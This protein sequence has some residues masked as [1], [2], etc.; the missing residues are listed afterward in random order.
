VSIGL[1]PHRKRGRGFGRR[2]EVAALREQALIEEARRRARQRRLGNLAAVALGLAVLFQVGFFPGGRGS[3]DAPAARPALRTAPADGAG[4]IAIADSTGSLAVVNPDGSA[5]RTLS[6]CTAPRTLRQALHNNCQVAEPAWSPDGMRLAFVRGQFPLLRRSAAASLYVSDPAATRPRLLARCGSCGRQYA[7]ERGISWSPDGTQIAFSATGGRPAE[8]SLFMVD[9]RSGAVRRLTD[10]VSG[11]ADAEP[12]WSPDGQLIVFSRF[13]KAGSSL[14]TVRPD[15]SGL[16]KI[17]REAGA[18]DPRWSPD[19]QLIAYDAH[20][21]SHDLV[22]VSAADGS[23][24]SRLIASG[25]LGAGPGVP[26]FSPDGSRIVYFSTP[27]MSGM[28]GS[29]VWTVNAD[30]TARRRLAHFGCCVDTWAPPVWSPDGKQI[31]F[32][33]DH[34]ELTVTRDGSFRGTTKGGTY[35]VNTDGSA[36]TRISA[37]TAAALSWQRVR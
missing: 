7:Y 14:Y 10:C 12:D 5:L 34:Q 16:T 28:F 18:M 9:L 22:Y 4:K 31:A 3:G 23:Q 17:R 13:T 26:S 36:R 11:C 15:G 20:D 1:P 37:I 25:P 21:S 24:P 8:L 29:E 6:H 30:G 19:G 33:A 32:S 2:V 27:P 35:V